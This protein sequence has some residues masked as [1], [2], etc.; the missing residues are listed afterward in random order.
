MSLKRGAF[1]AALE[2]GR[3]PNIKSL[4]PNSKALIVSGKY[5]DRAMRTKSGSMAVAVNGRSYFIIRGALLA[6]NAT[7]SALI[8]EI[9]RS[10]GGADAYCA[11]NFWNI[12]RIVDAL[13]NQFNIRIPV[14][15]HADHYGIKHMNQFQ[16]ASIEIPTLFDAGISSIAID[17]SHMPDDENLLMNILLHPFIPDWAGFETEIGEIK[18]K[19]GLSTVQEAKFLIC[20]LNAHDIFPDWIALNNGTTHGIEKGSEGIQVD[21]TAKIHSALAPFKVSGAQHGTSGNSSERLRKIAMNTSTT[22]ANLATALQYISWGSKVDDYG[23]CVMG[24]DG[25]FVKLPGCGMT[26]KLWKEMFDY[27]WEHK[28]KIG[29]MKKLCRPFENKLLGQSEE[30]Q[31]RMTTGITDFLSPFM[32]DV[33]NSS[34]TGSLV[35]ERIL[36][37]GSYDLGPKIGRTEDPAEWTEEKIAERIKEIDQNKGKEGDFSE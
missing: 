9:A 20:G 17:A 22:K 29:D 6:A 18:G 5:I 32:K 12:A 14:A 24:S 26:D 13:C 28:F 1:E 15:I 4:F 30:I 27:A 33:C 34:G 31:K 37:T 25:E 35:I 23:N 10:E 3:P 8:I 16:A 36:E 21:L 7:D 19:T 11:V 2:I